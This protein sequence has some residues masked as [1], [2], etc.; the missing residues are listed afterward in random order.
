MP[1]LMPSFG[2][3][4]PAE[5]PGAIF[6]AGRSAG[7]RVPAP[8]G[9]GV[10]TRTHPATFAADPLSPVCPP[11]GCG[12]HRPR[13]NMPARVGSLPSPVGATVNPMLTCPMNRLVPEQELF[14]VDQHPAE[15]LQRRAPLAG[16]QVFARR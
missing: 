14:V 12:Q 16:F 4:S 6:A 5:L 13:A 1:V 8:A 10:R 3:P 11:S 7:E 9:V 15:V 2:P